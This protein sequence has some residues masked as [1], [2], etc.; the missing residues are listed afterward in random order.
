MASVSKNK[1]VNNWKS[2]VYHI[3][4]SHNNRHYTWYTH[5]L[6]TTHKLY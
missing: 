3:Y 6:Y 1:K 4:V 5:I 2:D